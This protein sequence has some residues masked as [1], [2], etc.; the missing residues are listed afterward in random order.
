MQFRKRFFFVLVMISVFVFPA[1]AQEPASTPE[2]E[3]PA[4]PPASAGTVVVS[5]LNNP[6]NLFI[7]AD[8]TL[9]IAEAG[10]GGD[11]EGEGPFG[12]APYGESGR[13][14]SISA[15]GDITAVIPNLL[16][17]DAGFGQ[18]EGPMAVYVTADSYWV[19]LG[20]GPKALPEGKYAEALVQ[21]DKDTLEVG[22]VI[23]L[24]SYEAANNPDGGQE[25]VANPADLA[26]AEDGTIYIADAS[27][28]VVF[29]W[30]EAD[31]LSVFAVWPVS[32]DARQ[33]VPTS[34][35]VGTDGAV[36][37]GFLSGFPFPPGGARIERYAAD[38]TLEQTY[39]GLTLVT[40]VLVTAD[41]VYAVE[42]ASGFGDMG[43]IPNSGRI[44]KVTES[45]LEPVAEGLN[46]PYGMAID[47]A[48]NLYVTISSAFAAPDSGSVIRLEAM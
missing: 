8:G 12:P 2:V 34:V 20:I 46:I 17:L 29:K 43:Y 21:F 41:A 14:S 42:M 27:A 1:L 18:V 22:T 13:I 31:G 10:N 44:V 3:A 35:A 37:V 6:R 11:M 23:D 33:S 4:A 25:E 40:D 39:E 32:D 38:G 15:A 9:Y 48:G 36:Y 28:N 45:G 7:D 19:T 47:A 26:V 16:S 24:R 30:T 5:T